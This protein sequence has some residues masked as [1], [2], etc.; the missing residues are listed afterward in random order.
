[1]IIN[2]KTGN[3]IDSFKKKEYWGIAHGCNCFCTMGRGI[4][5]TIKEEFP[6]AYN[7]DCNFSKKGDR[8]K[9]GNFTSVSTLYGLIYNFYTQYTYWDKKDMLDYNAIG[10]CFRQLDEI[11]LELKK[12]GMIPQNKIFGIPKI[13]AGL[14]LGD[15]Y[16]IE[17]I[18]NEATP[19]VEI[20]VV[21]LE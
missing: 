18:I 21:V 17:K 15:W 14:A 11:Y 12:L 9:L 5:K 3:L 1:M 16:K 7:A 10:N 13:G 4:A 2:Y 8:K 20:E 6:D 19:N